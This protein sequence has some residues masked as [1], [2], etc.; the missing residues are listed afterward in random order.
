M[1]KNHEQKKKTMTPLPSKNSCGHNER[2]EQTKRPYPF[3]K[4]TPT[5]AA[6]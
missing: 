3:Q 4:N 1:K 6:G 2:S 5:T